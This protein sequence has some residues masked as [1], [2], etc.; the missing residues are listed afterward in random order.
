MTNHLRAGKALLYFVL[1]PL[2]TI[3]SVELGFRAFFQQDQSHL[4]LLLS[5]SRLQVSGQSRPYHVQTQ[6][7]KR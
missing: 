5:V 6:A 3:L 2:F 4:N 1:M 7:G